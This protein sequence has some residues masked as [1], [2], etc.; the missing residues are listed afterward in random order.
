MGCAH[1]AAARLCLARVAARGGGR[2]WAMKSCGACGSANGSS[3][4][5][6]AAR[7]GGG[8]GARRMLTGT[9]MLRTEP[10]RGLVTMGVGGAESEVDGWWVFGD[11]P[12]AVRAARTDRLTRPRVVLGTALK[13]VDSCACDAPASDDQL[14]PNMPPLKM[15]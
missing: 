2:A 3:M 13:A 9:D 4:M 6:I 11:A 12:A 7:E 8:G 14:G 5:V 15:R 1:P 10:L